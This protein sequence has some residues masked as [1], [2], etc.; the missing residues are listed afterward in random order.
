MAVLENIWRFLSDLFGDEKLK[1]ELIVSGADEI[2]FELR[3]KPEI[4]NVHFCDD[5]MVPCNPGT[6][7]ELDWCVEHACCHDRCESHCG[8]CELPVCDRD[9]KE[10]FLVVKWKVEGTRKIH[11]EVTF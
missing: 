11:W 8:R 3:R 7:F 10:W 9:H 2:K 4:V 6:D 5:D 1:G